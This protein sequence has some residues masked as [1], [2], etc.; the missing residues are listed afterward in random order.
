MTTYG[1]RGIHCR[2]RPAANRMAADVESVGGSTQDIVGP[3]SDDED[4]AQSIGGTTVLLLLLLHLGNSRV[5]V[6]WAPEP[7]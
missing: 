5:R 3:H 1:Q 2:V 7:F 6:L 4:D